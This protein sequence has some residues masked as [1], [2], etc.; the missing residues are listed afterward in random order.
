MKPQKRIVNAYLHI[1]HLGKTFDLTSLSRVAMGAAVLVKP[2]RN[3]VL[4][5]L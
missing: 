4:V 1:T 2:H 3:G 5:K